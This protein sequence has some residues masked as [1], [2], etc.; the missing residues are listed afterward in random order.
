MSADAGR[1]GL[2]KRV[3]FNMTAQAEAAGEALHSPN[4]HVAI[5]RDWGFQ[6]ETAS[7]GNNDHALQ[8]LARFE[9]LAGDAI[10]SFAAEIFGNTLD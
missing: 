8:A 3:I 7:A 10:E 9:S 1:I 5:K 2:S 4:G 6:A